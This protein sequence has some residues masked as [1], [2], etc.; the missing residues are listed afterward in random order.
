MASLTGWL[1]AGS[2]VVIAASVSA[3]LYFSAGLPLMEAG[4]IGV[5][6]LAF[7]LVGQV[8]GSR[9]REFRGLAT[10]LDDIG[11]ASGKVVQW[12]GN[13]LVIT[14]VFVNGEL[15]VKTLTDD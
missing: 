8:I 7:M 12:E 5:A 10:R 13:D 14:G 9:R 4:W 3:V 15:T 6:A 11:A 2:M 1:I